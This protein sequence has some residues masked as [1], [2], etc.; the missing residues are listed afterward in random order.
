MVVQNLLVENILNQK[1]KSYSLLDFVEILDK[2]KNLDKDVKN[3]LLAYK[4]MSYSFTSCAWF[5]SD[6]SGIE[7]IH[8]IGYMIKALDMLS[9]D[10]TKQKFINSLKSAKSNVNTMRDGK[11]IAE[12]IIDVYFKP[13]SSDEIIEAITKNGINKENTITL[14]D[15]ITI[16]GLS[17]NSGEYFE[18]QNTVYEAIK[19]KRYEK[20]N[21]LMILLEVLN[22]SKNVFR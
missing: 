3:A 14:L 22:I 8:N 18:T 6:I 12:R 20:S 11:T 9:M 10:D 1:G 7:T 4:W 19:N 16:R 15:N 13:K 5:F 21:E 2:V 17:P